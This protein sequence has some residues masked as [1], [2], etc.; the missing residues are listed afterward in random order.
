MDWNPML[1]IALAAGAILTILVVQFVYLSIVLAWEDQQTRG[2]G[3]YGLPADRRR[4]F[5][6]TLR[7]HARVL[8]PILRVLKRVSSVTFE[9]ASFTHD[10]IA[11]PKGTCSL[12]SFRRGCAYRAR[13]DDVFVVT[14]MKCG[15]TWM[16][17]VVFEV[18]QRGSGNLVESGRTLYAV[19]P[20][21][22][23]L[24][25]VPI[26]A[27]PL[28]GSERPARIIKTHL[29]ASHCPYSP[30]ARYVYVA[31]H[32]VSCFASCA[33]FITTNLGVF[34]PGLDAVERW[35]CSEDL[36]WWGTWPAHV[37]GWWDLSRRADNVMFVHFEEMKR[38][39][40]AVVTNVAAFL[41][42]APLSHAEAERV[43]AKCSFEYMQTHKDHFEMHPP[44]ILAI[45][46]ELFVR[47]TADRH[48]DVPEDVRRR[49]AHWCAGT[50][51]E[52][53]YPLV[54]QYPDVTEA[55]M[56]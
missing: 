32:P 16:Q 11:G 47:G 25:S 44:H 6:R 4:R 35:Y 40:S 41:G 28:I 46:A 19:S 27:A 54:S 53:A 5:K 56:P 3:Y 30:D 52:S 15:T 24:K 13:P 34:A 48:K 51:A 37:A 26:D 22:E 23:A 36:M 9:K 50:M 10:G 17:H 18:L 29:P 49:V 21:L 42:V 31:R 39:L 12:E 33:D 20:W 55:R 8:Y 1:W 43:V 38:D 45:D 7:L 14:Q 2:L